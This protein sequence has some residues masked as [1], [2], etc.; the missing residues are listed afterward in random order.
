MPSLPLRVLVL[1]DHLFQRSVA[2]SLL[3]QLGCSEVLEAG[4]GAEALAILQAVGSVD[5]VLCD[6]QMEGMDGLEF[7]QRVGATGQLGAIL[8]SSCMPSDVRRAVRQMGSLLGLNMLGD[9]AKP[10]QAETLRQFLEDYL[11]AQ[12]SALSL[13]AGVEEVSEEQIQQA[14]IDQQLEPYYQPKFDLRTGEVLGVEVLA[15]WNHPFKGLLPPAAFLPTAER[16]GLIDELLFSLMRQALSL[17]S[18]VRSQGAA[19]NMAFN[20]QAGQL[21]SIELTSQIKRILAWYQTPGSSLTF[22]LTESGLLEVPAMSLENLVRLRMMGCRLSIDDFGA[23]FSSLQRLCQLPFNEIKLDAEFVRGLNHEPRCRAVISSTL[24]LG[25]T[26][27]M[28]VVIEGIETKEQHR[29][30][31]EL[32][33]TQGQ[34]Y[35]HARPMNGA[36]LRHWLQRTAHV[37]GS[38]S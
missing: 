7:I 27:G 8:I 20:L 13:P 5:V 11:S 16:C 26:L 38:F 3:K 31:L 34:G 24:A 10:L 12:P 32:G 17:Q 28:S 1:E 6:L 19:L 14:F 33:C 4:H 35:W 23:G 15:R 21:T 36:D 18:Q 37:A 29:E 30:L 2:V 9:I 22:E 25:K